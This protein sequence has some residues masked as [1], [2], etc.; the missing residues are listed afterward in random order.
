M[1]GRNDAISPPCCTRRK[2]RRMANILGLFIA[3]FPAMI[4]PQTENDINYYIH[5]LEQGGVSTVQAAMPDLMTQYQNTPELT[6]LQARLEPDGLEAV[7]SYR[8]LLENFPKSD[9]ADDALYHLYLYDYATGLYQ[10]ADADMARLRVEYPQS[11][12]LATANEVVIPRDETGRPGPDAVV[13]TTRNTAP[14]GP[15]PAAISTPGGFVLQ[16][17]AFST[18]LNAQKQKAF[19]EKLGYPVEISGKVVEN[20]NLFLVWVGNYRSADDAK[21]D[22]V[23]IKNRCKIASMVIER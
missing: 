11:G 13:Q 21:R 20:K 1:I 3:L 2:I 15:T 4:F 17:G 19:F 9:F 10:S 7:K 14:A 22:G 12:T 5:T 18:S 23:K 16:V 6:Y 8:E